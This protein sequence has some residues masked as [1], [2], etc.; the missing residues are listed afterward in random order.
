MHPHRSEQGLGL[1]LWVDGSHRGDFE[2][3]SGDSDDWSF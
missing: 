1:S 3:R 2:L